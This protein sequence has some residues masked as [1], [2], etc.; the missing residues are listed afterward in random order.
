MLQLENLTP[1]AASTAIFPNAQAIDTLYIVVKASF[2]ING[3]L[4]LADEQ[5]APNAADVYWGEPGNSSLRYA[6][7]FLT[8]KISSD[9]FIEGAAITPDSVERTQLD[10]AITV[11]ELNHQI[12]VFGDREWRNGGISAPQPFASTPLVFENAFG[13]SQQVEDQHFVDARNP[14]GKGFCVNGKPVEGLPLPNLELPQQ[15][16]ESP[17]DLPPPVA[18]GPVAPGWE[19]RASLAGS[20]DLRWQK[21]RAPFLPLD[22]QAGFANAAPFGLLYPGFLKGG[23]AISMEGMHLSGTLRARVPQVSLSAAI[24]LSREEHQQPFQ[25][26][27]LTITPNDLRLSVVWKAAF[28]CNRCQEKIRSITIKM[29]QQGG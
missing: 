3:Q 24:L 22:Y 4:S 29:S 18:C 7:D 14:V 9:I 2:C 27:T 11:G 19:P 17:R 13:G 15:L 25:L 5:I 28:T 20:Y 1:F 10:V 21:K 8:Q 6:S 16:I 26:E 23:E 12:R